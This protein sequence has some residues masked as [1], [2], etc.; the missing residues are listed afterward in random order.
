MKK[1]LFAATISFALASCT[2]G[3]TVYPAR[4]SEVNTSPIIT[5]IKI[6]DYDTDFSK[7]VEGTASGLVSKASA[8]D[9]FKEQAIINACAGVGADFLI[10]PTYNISTKGNV[11]T[12]VVKGYAAKYSSAR[13][14]VP[15]DSIH[16]KYS[17]GII[18]PVRNSGVNSRI[19]MVY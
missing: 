8:V 3:V 16:L 12:V 10:N 18:S 15:A 13:S 6:V 1:Y 4:Q 5:P 7:K 14:A 2:T 17:G 9:Y 19:K 11:V